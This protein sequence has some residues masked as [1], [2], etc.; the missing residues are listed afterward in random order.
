MTQYNTPEI[1]PAWAEAGDKNDIPTNAEV[2]EGWP[3][4]NTPP[5][6]Q[7]FNWLQNWLAR[8]VRAWMQLGI[9]QWNAAEDYPQWA[10]VLDPH[11]GKTY[12]AKRANT[13]MDPENSPDD[14]ERWGYSASDPNIDNVPTPPIWDND[15]TVVNSEFVN[16]NGV[17]VPTAARATIDTAVTNAM[18]GGA[19][20]FEHA[21][22]TRTATMP[23]A[24]GIPVGRTLWIANRCTDVSGLVSIAAT[25][26]DKI[27]PYGPVVTGQLGMDDAS[28]LLLYYGEAICLRSNGNN[29]YEAI[30]F[31]TRRGITQPATAVGD[32]LATLDAVDARINA[33]FV[34][35]L[36]L[37]LHNDAPESGFLQA[38][39]AS[40]SRTT[41]SALFNKIT[42]AVSGNNTSGQNTITA[43]PTAVFSRAQVGMPIS[44]PGIGAGVTISAVN[45][46]TN[47]ITLSSPTSSG[48]SGL[49]YRICPWGVGDGST[50]FQLP[51]LRGL[52]LRGLDMARGI[53]LNRVLGVQQGDDLISHNHTVPNYTPTGSFTQTGTAVTLAYSAG[54]NYG[55]SSTGGTETRPKN[56]AVQILI[57]Y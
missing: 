25:G 57:K 34:G 23:A 41:Y 4:T 48:G 13:N 7:R 33:L 29:K 26:T 32:M 30:V 16:R 51:D 43:V 49:S 15:N 56:H 45:S 5:T 36:K 40:V 8:G 20:I 1:I 54:V 12:Q 6:R 21:A 42:I 55:T 17:F 2:Q 44:G 11:T 27:S 19:L 46:G 31:K 39:G 53:D 10:K 22:V 18:F 3:L 35:S 52:F 9:P 47:T 37:V 38:A 50:T 14:W 24:S 28:T